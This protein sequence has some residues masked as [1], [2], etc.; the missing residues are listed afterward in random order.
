MR[1]SDTSIRISMVNN[2]TRIHLQGALQGELAGNLQAA[3]SKVSFPVHIDM[4]YTPY[5]TANGLAS[6]FSFY[7][8]H[9][10]KPVLHHVNDA[11]RELLHLSG[12]KHYVVLSDDTYT[13]T[14]KQ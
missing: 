7:Q 3:V 4:A 11:I 8:H 14:D 5:I 2:T 10:K 13:T 6:I 9:A 12:V 1:Q